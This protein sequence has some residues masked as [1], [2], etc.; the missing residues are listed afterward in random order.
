MLKDER[1]WRR[2]KKRK[3]KSVVFFEF[4]VVKSMNF[5]LER[6]GH[7][8]GVFFIIASWALFLSFIFL[9]VRLDIIV[10]WIMES[11]DHSSHVRD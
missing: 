3:E 6:L 5:D 2:K 11:W 1:K 10:L 9:I 4:F 8:N 7:Q